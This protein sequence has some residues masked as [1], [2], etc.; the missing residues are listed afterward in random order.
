MARR[1]I[2]VGHGAASQA[3][4]TKLL[5]DAGVTC[6]VDVRRYPGSRTHPHVG[7]E[8]LARWLPMAGIGYRWE[9]RLG[10]RRHC[11]MSP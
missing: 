7:R 6:L 9:E 4:V 10:G 8:A 5:R 3:E 1:L 11:G 2:P